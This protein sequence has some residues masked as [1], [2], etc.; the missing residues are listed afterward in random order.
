MQISENDIDEICKEKI[1]ILKNNLE[2]S[3]RV[4]DYTMSKK[5]KNNIEKLKLFGKKISE[6]ERNKSA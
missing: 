6:L 3:I 1:K 5:I 4:E 2:E